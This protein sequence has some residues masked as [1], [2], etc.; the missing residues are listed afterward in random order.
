MNMKI[1]VLTLCAA[2]AAAAAARAADAEKE[3]QDRAAMT[4]KHERM[5]EMH[6]KAAECLKSGKPA[7]ECHDAMMKDA[8]AG[9]ERCAGCPMC[10][11]GKGKGMGMG[12]KGKGMRR[13]A[14]GAAPD[15]KPQEDVKTN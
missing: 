9:A 10:G 3:A 8:P 11:P 4:Q 14:P 7:T 5:A 1:L 2:L 6:R 12:G 13:G 15:V